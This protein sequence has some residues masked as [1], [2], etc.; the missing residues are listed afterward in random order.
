MS[1]K[2][3]FA[4][5]LQKEKE[6]LK[7]QHNAAKKNF[8]ESLRNEWLAWTDNY[9][10]QQSADYAKAETTIRNNCFKERDKQIEIAIVRLEKESREMRTKLQQSFDNKLE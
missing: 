1:I 4:F 7:E 3:F 9:K 5:S 2:F 10:K 6:T 8:E